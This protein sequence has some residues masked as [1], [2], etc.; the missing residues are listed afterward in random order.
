MNYEA[1]AAQDAR[2]LLGF[3][4]VSEV[5]LVSYRR[6]RTNAAMAGVE[7]RRAGRAWAAAVG[8]LSSTCFA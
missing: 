6:G 3:F 8:I 1:A 5:E 7:R 4:T 2:Q